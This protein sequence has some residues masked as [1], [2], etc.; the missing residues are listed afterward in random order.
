MAFCL[1]FY[2]LSREGLGSW[3]QGDKKGFSF[4]SLF[5]EREQK[6]RDVERNVGP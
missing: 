2:C 4:K 1:Y 6:G 3:K 5:L